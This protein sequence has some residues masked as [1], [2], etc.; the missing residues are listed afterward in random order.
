MD[1]TMDKIKENKTALIAAGSVVGIAT[2][3]YI[4]HRSLK[5]RK[6][7]PKTGPYP[8]S[9]LPADCYDVVI[10]GA[11]P[12]GSTAGYFLS[13]AGAKVALLDKEKFPRDKYCGDAVCTPALRIL[14]EMGVVQALVKNNEAHFADSGGFVSPSGLAYIGESKYSDQ[15]LLA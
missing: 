4:I 6:R 10:V 15:C 13:K 11:G 9:S 2:G 5:G 7:A 8:V 3:A 1:Y 14:E 12:S